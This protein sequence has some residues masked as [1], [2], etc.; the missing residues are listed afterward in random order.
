MAREPVCVRPNDI[1]DITR[2]GGRQDGPP[3]QVRFSDGRVDDVLV[4]GG[5][6][7]S[8]AEVRTVWDFRP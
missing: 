3:A 2:I 1:G 4:R 5:R 6:E 7:L 8:E